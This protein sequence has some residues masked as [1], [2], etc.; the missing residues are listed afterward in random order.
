M[1]GKLKLL[2]NGLKVD[3]LGNFHN[4]MRLV[5]LVLEVE[6][7]VIEMI[8]GITDQDGFPLNMLLEYLMPSQF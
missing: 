4:L 3:G 5:S 6:L 1:V 8:K 7:K 2:T